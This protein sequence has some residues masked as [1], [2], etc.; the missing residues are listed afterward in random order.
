MA[1]S[2]PHSEFESTTTAGE[3][4]SSFSTTFDTTSSSR[5]NAT[6]MELERRQLHHTIQILKL[7]LSQKQLLMESLQ[8]EHTSKVEE[9]QE[10]LADAE[11]E[12]KL[13]CHRLQALTQ[14]H[15]VCASDNNHAW[16]ISILV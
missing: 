10:Q 15:E 1:S 5:L 4:S 11:C 7:E 9:L 16:T 14:M 6:R 2:E 12:K 3:P 13:L 8:S